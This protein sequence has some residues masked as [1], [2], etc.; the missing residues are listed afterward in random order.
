VEKSEMIRKII[1]DEDFIRCP[2]CANSLNRYTQ[3]HPDGVENSMIA[4]LLMMTEEEVDTLYQ[5][6]LILL[7][8]DVDVD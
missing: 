8:K 2:K 6:T 1:E 5:S 7:R 3:R 4:R